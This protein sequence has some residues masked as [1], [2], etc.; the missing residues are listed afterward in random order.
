VI[1]H[2][3][4]KCSPTVRNRMRWQFL[5]C[6]MRQP[7]CDRG[8]PAHAQ[9]LPGWQSAE[10]AA[11]RFGFCCLAPL[12]ASRPA[13]CCPPPGRYT[14]APA[15]PDLG[16]GRGCRRR[17]APTP[18]R[19]AEAPLARTAA[20]KKFPSL[21]A[22]SACSSAVGH[23]REQCRCLGPGFGQRL[24]QWPGPFRILPPLSTPT[25]SRG[26]LALP[27]PRWAALLRT[28][29]HGSEP[30]TRQPKQAYV[31]RKPMPDT[32]RPAVAFA[33]C[34]GLCV[35]FGICKRAHPACTSSL[36]GLELRLA[37]PPRRGS[38]ARRQ[39]APAC[40]ETPVNFGPTYELVSV[41]ARDWH[42]CHPRV[43]PLL[44]AV[45]TQ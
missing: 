39:L 29:S 28:A 2:P 4:S 7:R 31:R 17:A 10:G 20:R 32:T 14:P 3:V 44:P 25:G 5:V 30:T 18:R 8:T 22:A 40:D 13:F 33:A 34:Q 1:N 27:A 35:S 19:P 16:G 24:G 9:S 36:A 42:P 23:A 37:R 41:F 15:P 43:L 45:L 38:N 26:A 12:P 11:C 21:R 6:A